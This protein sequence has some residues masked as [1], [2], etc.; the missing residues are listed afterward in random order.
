MLTSQVPQISDSGA[1]K[2][3]EE[4]SETLIISL[5]E[6]SKIKD[7]FISCLIRRRPSLSFVSFCRLL[8]K[9]VP[10]NYVI[11]H[12]GNQKEKQGQVRSSLARNPSYHRSYGMSKNLSILQ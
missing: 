6:V 8:H 3:A 4:S 2:R 11:E 7:S 12:R 1:Q 10:M 5:T 9:I